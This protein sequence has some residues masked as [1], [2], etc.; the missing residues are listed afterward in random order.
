[1]FFPGPRHH[2]GSRGVNAAPAELRAVTRALDDYHGD[3]AIAGGWAIDLF[4]GRTTRQHG[5]VDVAV[6]RDEQHVLRA[7]FPEWEFRLAVD[8]ELVEWKRDHYLE[9]PLHEVH[10]S[11][12]SGTIEFLLNDRRAD[13]WVYRRDSRVE[14]SLADSVL[15]AD[16]VPI[17]APEIVLLYKSKNPRATDETDLANVAPVLSADAR[18][19]LVSALELSSPGHAWAEVLAQTSVGE[20]STSRQ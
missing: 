11:T 10:A 3:W 9:L 5:D 20:R 18:A 1:M 6:F 15:R 8:G 16:I 12:P 2:A 17:L 7:S 4:L 14:R 19:W 13:R